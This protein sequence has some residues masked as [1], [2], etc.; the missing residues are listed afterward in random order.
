M[1]GLHHALQL[2]TMGDALHLVP[3][4]AGTAFACVVLFKLAFA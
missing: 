2:Y 1:R 3:T 4:L